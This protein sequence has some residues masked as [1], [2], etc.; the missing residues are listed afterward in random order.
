MTPTPYF[1]PN[2][3]VRSVLLL[4]ALTVGTALVARAQTSD[5]DAPAAR[6]IRVAQE[7][8][9]AFKRADANNDNRLNRQEAAR[10]P[11][12]E[13]HFDQIDTNKDQALSPEEFQAAL[14]T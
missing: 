9:A 5:L 11:V 7:I 14:K 10:F 1:I 4:A 2:F 3:E 8:D 6:A 12:I 13:Q